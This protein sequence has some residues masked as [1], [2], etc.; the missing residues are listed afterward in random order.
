MKKLWKWLFGIRKQQ[1]NI[2]DVSVEFCVYCK[3]EPQSAG[4]EY[5]GKCIDDGNYIKQN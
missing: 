1:C 4:S 5:C 2:H 3:K